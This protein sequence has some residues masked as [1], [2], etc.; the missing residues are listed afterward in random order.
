[1]RGIA[2]A[3]AA[4]ALF[5]GVVLLAFSPGSPARGRSDEA[6]RSRTERRAEALLARL[7]R[8]VEQRNAGR[9]RA[10]LHRDFIAVGEDGAI[11]DRDAFVRSMTAGSFRGRYE[12][13]QVRGGRR[14]IV[15]V[16]QLAPASR[17][18]PPWRDDSAR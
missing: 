10:V 12:V 15:A 14:T 11:S 6:R 2:I 5:T 18:K 1:M 4:A 9:L 8:A 3:V 13:E 7:D 16:G 17:R